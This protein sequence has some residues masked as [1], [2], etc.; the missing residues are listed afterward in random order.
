MQTCFTQ[1]VSFRDSESH[2]DVLLSVQSA[3]G[4]SGVN[5]VMLLSVQSASGDS[6]GH[7]DTLFSFQS[8]SETVG[9]MQTRFAQSMSF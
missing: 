9:A 3:S 5:A 7:G 8:A 4:H 2:A 6:D 1:L